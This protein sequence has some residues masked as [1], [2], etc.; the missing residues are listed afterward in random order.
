MEGFLCFNPSSYCDSGVLTS[1]VLDYPHPNDE[2]A[3]T[4]GYVYR[5]SAIPAVQGTYFYA[6]FCVGLV[7]SFRY[8][9]GQPT[10]QTDWP[11]LSPPGK[12]KITRNASSRINPGSQTL[13]DEK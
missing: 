7:K 4:G 11:S 6:D 3:V 12:R 9:N 13:W 1:P 10:D 5:G 8:Q 2:C